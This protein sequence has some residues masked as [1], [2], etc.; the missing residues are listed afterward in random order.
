MAHEI[1]EKDHMMYVGEVPWH[2][3]G[4]GFDKPITAKE[5]AEAAQMTWTVEKYPLEVLIGSERHKVPGYYAIT[6]ADTKEVFHIGG[7]RFTPFQNVPSL[8]DFVDTMVASGR[9]L[10]TS[11]GS[12]NGG[13]RVWMQLRLDK[14]I[15]IGRTKDLIDR[16]ITVSNT[17][18]GT[19][20]LLAMITPTR[21]VC[22]NTERIAI[23]GA[24]DKF[25]ARHTTNIGSKAILAREYLGLADAYF[26][27]FMEGVN[28]LVKKQMS[29]DSLKKIFGEVY[30]LK[31]RED[32]YLD[33]KQRAPAELAFN[34]TMQLFE[35]GKGNDMV[36]VK[37]TAWAAY[38]AVTE[39]LD[40]LSPVSGGQGGASKTFGSKTLAVV[41]KRIDSSWFG[42]N[43]VIRQNAWDSLIAYAAK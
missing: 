8:T 25:Y 13:R 18:D 28:L 27:N 23:K 3:L 15:K 36:G 30:E 43:Q 2:G 40:W 37:G 11:A 12:L 4:T 31:L 10:I 35:I 9:A 16:Y 24:S 33:D 22:G 1:T 21:V 5:A 17:H 42:R 14:A 6:R 34:T 32:G 20:A 7:E 39:Y 19:R 26:E 29:N 38:N 41:D